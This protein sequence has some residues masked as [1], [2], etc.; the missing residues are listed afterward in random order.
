MLRPGGGPV[1]RAGVGLVAGV[2]VPAEPCCRR[3]AHRGHP[4]ERVV[5]VLRRL[6]G[7]GGL[8][9][10]LG[11]LARRRGRAR[12]RSAG[13]AHP[14]GCGPTLAGAGTRGRRGLD[15]AGESRRHCRRRDPRTTRS[16]A[17]AGRWRERPRATRS[18]ATGAPSPT[19]RRRREARTCTRGTAGRSPASARPAATA[20]IPFA[21]S[22]RSPPGARARAC[23]AAT[24]SG[25]DSTDRHRRHRREADLPLL[26]PGCPVPERRDPDQGRPSNSALAHP[27]ATPNRVE[28]L[29]T[30]KLRPRAHRTEPMTLSYSHPGVW[31]WVATCTRPDA[32]PT[33]PTRACRA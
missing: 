23:T 21:P 6:G 13:A 28:S 9:G 2:R 7:S 1:Q 29:M 14:Q 11:R 24:R 30:T 3:L 31:R 15:A 18:G 5:E 12:A 17:P 25:A 32:P 22:R 4:A 8:A 26:P 16:L 20:R 19:T 10:N 33:T 27:G